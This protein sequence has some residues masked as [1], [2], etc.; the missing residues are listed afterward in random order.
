MIMKSTQ[1]ARSSWTDEPVKIDLDPEVALRALLDVNP[2]AYP[3]SE[4]PKAPA[5]TDRTK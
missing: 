5:E 4:R 1:T 3:D 2:E